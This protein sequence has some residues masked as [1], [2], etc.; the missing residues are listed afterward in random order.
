MHDDPTAIK[1]DCMMVL[2]L[3]LIVKCK[4]DSNEVTVPTLKIIPYIPPQTPD[5]LKLEDDSTSY[6]YL[7]LFEHSRPFSEEKKILGERSSNVKSGPPHVCNTSEGCFLFKKGVKSISRA[8]FPSSPEL[9]GTRTNF[10]L[11]ESC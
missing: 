5:M 10:K 8:F 2:R 1:L 6:R 4:F 9:L 3:I 7:S 11:E